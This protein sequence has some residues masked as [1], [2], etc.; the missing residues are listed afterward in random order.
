[1][2]LLRSTIIKL[3]KEIPVYDLEVSSASHNFCL[4]NGVVAHNSK[5]ISDGVCGSIY[6][7]YLNLDAAGQLSTKYIAQNSSS[8]LAERA[9]RPS[10]KFQQMAENIFSIY[11]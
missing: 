1:M 7:L 5:D 6:N 11:N 4:S 2:K 10:D 8:A 3:E 9:K